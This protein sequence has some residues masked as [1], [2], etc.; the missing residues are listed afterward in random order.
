MKKLVLVAGAL[1]L[2]SG[3]AVYGGGVYSEVK[4]LMEK[5][6]MSLE[7]FIT[8]L[9]KADNADDVVAALDNYSKE[10]LNLVP[11]MKELINKYPELKELKEEET[12]PEELKPVMKKMEELGKRMFGVFAK[13]QQYTNEPKVK[14]AQKRW[15]KA[16]AALEALEGEEKEQEKE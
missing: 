3:V 13:V 2:L 15:H 8:G 16:M 11:K 5:M 7:K 6:A 14:E 1:L 12:P 4:P 9:E 10:I